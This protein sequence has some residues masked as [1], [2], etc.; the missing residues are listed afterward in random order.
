[1]VRPF[2][3]ELIQEPFNDGEVRI[4]PA[5]IQMSKIFWGPG[6][7]KP[8]EARCRLKACPTCFLT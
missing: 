3:P 1:M 7:L 6:G 5:Y 8:A 4:A 2:E